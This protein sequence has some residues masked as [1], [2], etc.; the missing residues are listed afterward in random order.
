MS[1]LF[2]TTKKTPFWDPTKHYTPKEK[3]AVYLYNV[4]DLKVSPLNSVALNINYQY[5]KTSINTPIHEGDNIEFKVL[6]FS[7]GQRISI[8]RMHVTEINRARTLSI[9]DDRYVFRGYDETNKQVEVFSDHIR[10][11][12]IL[13]GYQPKYEYLIFCD[14]G[15]E[16]TGKSIFAVNMYG[17]NTHTVYSTTL[18]YPKNRKCCISGEKDLFNTEPKTLYD[19]PYFKIDTTELPNDTYIISLACMIKNKEKEIISSKPCNYDIGSIF[20]N[21]GIFIPYALLENKVI[22]DRYHIVGVCSRDSSGDNMVLDTVKINVVNSDDI[23]CNDVPYVELKNNIYEGSFPIIYGLSSDSTIIL[24][25][26]PF[27]TFIFHPNLEETEEPVTTI[28]TIKLLPNSIHSSVF[29]SAIRYNQLIDYKDNFN[30]YLD[31]A[32]YTT[33]ENIYYINVHVDRIKHNNVFLNVEETIVDQNFSIT[34]Y[35]NP[36]V[37]GIS[38]PVNVHDGYYITIAKYDATFSLLSTIE[39]SIN[40][41]SSEHIWKQICDIKNRKFIQATMVRE[42][43]LDDTKTHTKY[44]FISSYV[45]TFDTNNGESVNF[46]KI[47]VDDI[48]DDN[49]M[50]KF[51]VLMLEPGEHKIIGIDKNNNTYY[52][53]FIVN[54]DGTN[55]F[56]DTTA[57][58][59]LDTERVAEPRDIL[60]V[61]FMMPDTGTHYDRCDISFKLGDNETHPLSASGCSY[62]LTETGL[63]F[64]KRFTVD[65]SEFLKSV[66]AAIAN[67]TYIN[68][69]IIMKYLFIDFSI[70]ANHDNDDDFFLNRVIHIT[71]DK[72]SEINKIDNTRL[73]IINY[74]IIFRLGEDSDS[75]SLAYDE[76]FEMD[77]YFNAENVEQYVMYNSDEPTDSDV[78]NPDINEDI[79]DPDTPNSGNDD[80]TDDPADTGD[81]V[82][83]PASEGEET[84]PTDPEDNTTGE[85]TDSPTDNVEDQN[86]TD[87]E[88]TSEGTDNTT[89]EEEGT[90]ETPEV[91]TEDETV[92]HTSE[93][94]ETTPTDPEDDNS[95]TESSVTDGE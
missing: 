68:S 57:L 50:I 2:V 63:S 73:N 70:H 39:S 14:I 79:I 83:P 84:T 28:E 40:I 32:K 38:F 41:N 10:G 37:T 35:N 8:V 47:Y 80:N 36:A 22:N 33:D 17:V 12:R 19:N 54:D 16:D 61:Y 20:I 31:I 13:S 1:E 93:G 67:D 3:D 85:T 59:I 92:P 72:I 62:P 60:S 21:D 4:S 5:P 44:P 74:P 86:P 56:S 75:Y 66:K 76:L 55:D 30:V 87:P 51:K 69:D 95:E 45:T 43:T 78:E 34:K 25:N 94:E 88:D 46:E 65:I 11:V 82:D 52:H 64:L 77:N 26:I 48:S 81:N 29:L 89:P 18:Q 15:E 23:V 71:Y 49:E 24:Y 91:N 90:T 42:I 9:G 27:D 7:R 58:F 6:D 53:K